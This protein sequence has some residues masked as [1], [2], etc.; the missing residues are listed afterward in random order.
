MKINDV[1]TAFVSWPGGGKTRPVLIRRINDDEVIVYK[2]TTK[3][4]QKS[5]YIRQHYYKIHDLL[6]A[7]LDRDSYIDTI[8]LVGLPKSL[9]FHRI[10]QLSTDD[11]RGLARFIENN[12]EAGY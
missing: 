12:S 7:G 9:E 1:Y 5:F 4:R 6:T 11:I 3:Y 2:I 8:N 10:G